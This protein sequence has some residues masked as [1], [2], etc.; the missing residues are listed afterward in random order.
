MNWEKQLEGKDSPLKEVQDFFIKY[1]DELAN[2]GYQ[3]F[4]NLLQESQNEMWEKLEELLKEY[5]MYKDEEYSYQAL[6]KIKS[7]L[8]KPIK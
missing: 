7:L 1:S 4:L 2:K 3:L 5:E 6:D 8:K